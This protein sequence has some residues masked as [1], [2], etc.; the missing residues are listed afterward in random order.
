MGVG[1]FLVG[2]ESRLPARVSD[3]VEVISTGGLSGSCVLSKDWCR[4]E[5]LRAERR[6]DWR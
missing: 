4:R 6:G 5:K 3:G 2:P 1:G